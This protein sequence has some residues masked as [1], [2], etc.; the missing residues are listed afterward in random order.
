V[1]SRIEEIDGLVNMN[2][3]PG[4]GTVFTIDVPI[5][6]A[7]DGLPA[8]RRNPEAVQAIAAAATWR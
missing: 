2:S 1:R 7:G 8:R 6:F 5:S 3:T 4:A